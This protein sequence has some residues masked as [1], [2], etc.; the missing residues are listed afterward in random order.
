MS[1]FNDK[2]IEELNHLDNYIDNNR[3]NIQALIIASEMIEKI[4]EYDHRDSQ[5]IGY[6]YKDIRIIVDFYSPAKTIR[7]LHKDNKRFDFN[8]P[9]ACGIF[10]DEAHK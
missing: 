5:M 6:K 7:I 3:D 1:K 9:C 10:P 4:C 2:N 8:M